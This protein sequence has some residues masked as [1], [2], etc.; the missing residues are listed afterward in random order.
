MKHKLPIYRYR[1][2]YANF[3]SNIFRMALAANPFVFL[4]ETDT[5]LGTT[6]SNRN[7]LARLVS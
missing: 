1:L 2:L 4:H 5:R 7:F 6:L 3:V